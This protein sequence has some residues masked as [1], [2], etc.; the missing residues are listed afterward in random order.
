MTVAKRV[1]EILRPTYLSKRTNGD[2]YSFRLM[3]TKY[4]KPTLSVVV[5]ENRE[6][7]VEIPI[8]NLAEFVDA[9]NEAFDEMVNEGLIGQ[10]EEDEEGWDE[11]V[12]ESVT[13]KSTQ[14]SRHISRN[15]S[16]RSKSGNYNSADKTGRRSRRSANKTTSQSRRS[17]SR[18]S[19]RRIKRD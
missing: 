14:T 3:F 2:F 19:S 16:R 7:L 8:Q 12:E 5:Y 15:A 9:I 17:S 1:N 11:A 18:R 6:K 10:E 4:P 13:N